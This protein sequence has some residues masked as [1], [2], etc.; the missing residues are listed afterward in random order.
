MGPASHMAPVMETVEE[1]Y[2]EMEP[3]GETRLGLRHEQL[4]ML[5]LAVLAEGG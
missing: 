2:A 4:L 5:F 1:T 3:T